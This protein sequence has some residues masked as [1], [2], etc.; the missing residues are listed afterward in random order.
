V[1]LGSKKKMRDTVYDRY[2]KFW[3]LFK[4]DFPEIDVMKIFK[5]LGKLESWH[6]PSK[7]WK[8]MMLSREETKVYEWLLNK[9]H[10]PGTVY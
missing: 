2:L 3:D 8:G 10:H 6:Y 7:R 1:F 9:N 5:M 4:A